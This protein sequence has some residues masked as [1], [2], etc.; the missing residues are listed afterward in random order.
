MNRCGSTLS[1]VVALGGGGARGLAHLGVLR[2]LQRRQWSIQRIVGTSMGSLVGAVFA[3]STSAGEAIRKSIG[4]LQSED[5][6]RKRL[7]LGT[8]K[9]TKPPNNGAESLLGW[10]DQIK[11]YLWARRLLSRVFRRPSLLNGHILQSVVENLLPDIDLQECQPAL[12]IVT[13]DLKSG[14]KIVLESGS[15]RRAVQASAAIPGIF[16]PVPFGD[17][18]LCDMGVLQSLP[19]EVAHSYVAGAD[20]VVGS[21]VGP[22]LGSMRDCPSA[23]HVLLRMDEIAESLLRRA[24]QSRAQIL[25]QPSVGQFDWFEFT[26]PNHIIDA[27]FVAAEEGL[28]TFARS[29]ST[30]MHQRSAC[31]R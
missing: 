22:V 25:I 7:D 26:K 11:N 2:S 15:L 30:G 28:R 13:V 1:A 17:M 20:W 21:D 18:L 14:R 23:L 29:V 24:A 9:R 12:S 3:T 8:A 31:H 5:F 16:P 10:Y 4:Y 27:G 19:T 6:Q